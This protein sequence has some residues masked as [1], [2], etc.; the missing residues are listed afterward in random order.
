MSERIED[1]EQRRASDESK[2]IKTNSRGIIKYL[3]G[4]EQGRFGKKSDKDSDK[5]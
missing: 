1:Q 2:K 3:L 5:G 4:S